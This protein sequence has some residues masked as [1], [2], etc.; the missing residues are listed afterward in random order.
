MYNNIRLEKGLYSITGKNFTQALAALDPDS[1]YENTPLKNLDAFERQLK[2]FDIRTKGLNC[3]RVEKFFL[4]TESAILFPEYVRRMIKAGMDEAT[5]TGEICAA[6]SYTDSVDFRGLSVTNA[7]SSAAAE[8]N[9][10]PET[11]VRLATTP[12]ALTKFAGKL[13][14]SYE[15]VRKQRLET[16]GVI[17]KSM[18]ARISRDINKLCL[19]EISENARSIAVSGA[20]FSY[21]DL[22]NFWAGM[23]QY[24]MTT[25]FCTPDIMARIMAMNE[26]R[27]I[28]CDFMT[29]GFARTPYGV[30][31][32]KM[33]FNSDGESLVVGIDK[34]CAAEMIFG[35]DIIVDSD[36]L[37][38]TQCDEIACSV[39]VGFSVINQDA[40]RKMTFE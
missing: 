35:T 14:C 2:R 31:I 20:D 39:M 29:N 23:N 24:D 1:Q 21:S 38:S 17:L 12:K 6:V 34:N 30:T 36:K 40:V 9:S 16:F 4:S 13:S 37:I 22:T 18:G 32:V 10:L 33:P 25:M 27:L 7:T 15:S 5:L 11:K 19:E 3:D 28:A 26:M 8:G